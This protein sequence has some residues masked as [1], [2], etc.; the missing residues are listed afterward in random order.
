MYQSCSG[1]LDALSRHIARLRTS[2]QEVN[3]SD[4]SDECRPRVEAMIKTVTRHEFFPSVCK[5]SLCPCLTELWGIKEFEAHGAVLLMDNFSSHTCKNVSAVLSRE[6]RKIII[7]TSHTTYIFKMLDFMLFG[8]WKKHAMGLTTWEEEEQ[9]ISAFRIKVY[10]DFKQ[11]TIDMNTG[12][13]SEPLG[14]LIR[15]IKFHT[16]C[17]SMR[18]SS[19]KVLSS[20]SSGVRCSPGE[21]VE[22][23]ARREIWLE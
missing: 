3:A 1:F 16:N 9:T 23:M 13:S 18:K 4:R 11:K 19:G 17:S 6:K 8:A 14:S 7:F 2:S 20:S 10:N 5:F 21:A 12:W 22:G 15:S